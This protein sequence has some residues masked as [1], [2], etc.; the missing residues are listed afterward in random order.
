MSW[1]IVNEIKCL[2]ATV[3]FPWCKWPLM[4][5]EAKRKHAGYLK[6]WDTGP[7]PRPRATVHLYRCSYYRCREC[8]MW[9]PVMHNPPQHS[10]LQIVTAERVRCPDPLF[11]WTPTAVRQMHADRPQCSSLDQF[12]LNFIYLHIHSHKV[13]IYLSLNKAIQDGWYLRFL[14][15]VIIIT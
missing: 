7:P 6:E 5:G 10:P 1:V 4:A 15:P 12:N 9:E 13:V 14:Y 8:Q 3:C 11:P 2:I